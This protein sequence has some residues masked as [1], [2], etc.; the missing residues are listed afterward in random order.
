MLLLKRLKMAVRWSVLHWHQHR[1]TFNPLRV[2]LSISNSTSRHIDL[3]CGFSSLVLLEKLFLCWHW[4]VI[5]GFVCHIDMLWWWS[6]LQGILSSIELDSNRRKSKQ[7]LTS[8][9]ETANRVA[10]TPCSA[11]AGR[12]YI[13]SHTWHYARTCTWTCKRKKKMSKRVFWH[14]TGECVLVSECH[15]CVFIHVIVCL[16]PM[17]DFNTWM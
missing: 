8:C 4:Q 6:K 15:I 5:E 10:L 12:S 3:E 14:F 11:K 2:W 16:L 17:F 13:D 7:R 1:F 9:L